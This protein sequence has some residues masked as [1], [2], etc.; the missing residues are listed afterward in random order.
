MEALYA[1]LYEKYTA[2]KTKKASEWDAINK[3]QEVKF[4]DFMS[5]ADELK[6]GLTDEINKLRSEVIESRNEV[7]LI[8]SKSDKEC[9]E[10]QKLLMEEN[11]K[12]KMLAIEVER[13]QKLLD[14]SYSV[15]DGMTIQRQSGEVLNSSTR[16]KAGKSNNTGGRIDIDECTATPSPNKQPL[17]LVNTAGQNND[18]NDEVMSHEV[19]NGSRIMTQKRSREART[20][21]EDGIPVHDS[22]GPAKKRR[23]ELARE[24]P[25]VSGGLCYDQPP[26]CCRTSF[27]NT[28]D[29]EPT[30]CQFQALTEYIVGMKLSAVNQ[31]GVQWISAIHQTSGYSFS[32]T[33]VRNSTSGEAELVYKVATL[34]TFERVAAEWMRSV[35]RFSVSMC[36]IFFERLARVIKL[37]R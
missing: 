6:Q 24:S 10:Y 21:R 30:N 8:R 26:A 13:L 12:S 22:A 23:K 31:N 35:I 20:Q 4:L 1:K 28:G 9:A 18:R 32:L 25:E 11:E 37:H 27:D 33:W 5:A 16:R 29:G 34:G 19:S 15:K 36:P 7:T 17:N 14:E 2:L 3:D